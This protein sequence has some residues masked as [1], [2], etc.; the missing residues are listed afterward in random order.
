MSPPMGLP[1]QA[2]LEGIRQEPGALADG[3]QEMRQREMGRGDAPW[4]LR[5]ETGGKDG[6]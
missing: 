6:P 5:P 3:T 4:G 2:K 1:S